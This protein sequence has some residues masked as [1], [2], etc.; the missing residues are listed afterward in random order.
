MNLSGE[1]KMKK[2]LLVL[3]GAFVVSVS[4]FATTVNVLSNGSVWLDKPQVV[5]KVEVTF[6]EGVLDLGDVWKEAFVK[7]DVVIPFKTHTTSSRRHNHLFNVEMVTVVDIGVVYDGKRVSIVRDVVGEPKVMFTPYALLWLISMVLMSDGVW[8]V[9]AGENHKFTL[10]LSSFAFLFTFAA[11]FIA[12]IDTAFGSV[13]I[14]ALF[15]FVFTVVLLALAGT[16]VNKKAFYVSASGY[17]VFMTA[18]MT[19]FLFM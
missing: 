18:S 4:A 8:S 5:S 17:Y 7:K 15:A 9:Y 11:T 3:F 16:I 10:V 1:N 6:D 12:G 14:A 19:A 2:M 13:A